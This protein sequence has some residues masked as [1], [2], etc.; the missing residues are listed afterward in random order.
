MGRKGHA[1]GIFL[2]SPPRTGD[3]V[4]AFGWK[5]LRTQLSPWS[6]RRR[7]RPAR[8]GKCW[9]VLLHSGLLHFLLGRCEMKRK[10]WRVAFLVETPIRLKSHSKELA[11]LLLLYL[12]ETVLGSL[13]FVLFVANE[14]T[15]WFEYHGLKWSKHPSAWYLRRKM[16]VAV[17]AHFIWCSL[18]QS[19]RQRGAG[20][21]QQQKPFIASLSSA[22]SKWR[23]RDCESLSHN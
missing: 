3:F 4:P 20:V 16:M 9:P 13:G 17:V 21:V 18:L 12:S 22:H 14:A 2:F 8:M 11:N 7:S 1:R 23:E 15:E 6:G 19:D 5:R 10:L